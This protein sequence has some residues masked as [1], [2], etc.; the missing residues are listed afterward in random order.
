MGIRIF[1]QIGIKIVQDSLQQMNGDLNLTGYGRKL[2]LYLH[3]AAFQRIGIIIQNLPEQL[4]RIHQFHFFTFPVCCVYQEV[5]K[6]LICH[7]FNPQGL[8]DALLN[9]LI[10]LDF[11][12]IFLTPDQLQIGQKRGQRCSQ[13]MGHSGNQF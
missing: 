1:G 2:Q 3:T 9:Q 5:F 12:R 6:Q 10:H 13:I 8:T 4:V 11:I 7:V